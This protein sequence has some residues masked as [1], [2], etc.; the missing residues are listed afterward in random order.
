M[1]STTKDASL[2]LGT[3]DEGAFLTLT[4]EYQAMVGLSG[5]NRSGGRLEVFNKTGE[6]IA[7]VAPNKEG[8]GVLGLLDR[9]GKGRIY[10]SE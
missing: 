2:A 9:K 3:T 1:F 8:K 10:G 5:G 6:K 4:D 7:I